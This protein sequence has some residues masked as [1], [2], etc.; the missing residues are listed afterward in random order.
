MARL[1]R[2]RRRR[3]RQ[4]P[5]RGTSS[6]S[7]WSG[8]AS[9]RSASPR[10]SARHYIN[11]IPPEQEPW[12]PGDEDIERRIRAFIRWNAVVMVDQGEQARRRPR[13]PPVHLRVGAASTRSASTTSSAARATAAR[14]PG[15][16][17]GPRRAGHLRPRVPRRP[18]HRGPPRPLPARGRPAAGCRRTRTPGAC[19][20]SGSSRRCRWASARSTRSYQARFNRYLQNREIVDT[21]KAKVWCFVGDGEMDEPETHGRALARGARAA[22][23]PDLRRQLQPA[24]PRRPGARQ[25]QDHPGARGDR[26]AARAGT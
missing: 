13:R 11:T 9:S 25:R 10:W 1:P 20:T 4:G 6:A 3:P 19:P 7:S 8:R 23:Q 5:G 21:S 12:F 24:A 17:P 26:S 2:R 15:L 14:R 22:R 18:A 16:L